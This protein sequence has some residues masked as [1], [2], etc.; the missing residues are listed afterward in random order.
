V[1][2]GAQ[3]VMEATDLPVFFR[4]T[5]SAPPLQRLSRK[6]KNTRNREINAFPIKVSIIAK[7]TS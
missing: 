6:T 3:H 5:L 4:G 7:C 1:R 2:M